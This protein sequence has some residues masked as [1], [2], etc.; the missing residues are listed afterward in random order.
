MCVWDRALRSQ[1]QITYYVLNYQNVAE[2]DAHHFSCIGS[3]ACGPW[4][5]HYPELIRC[6]R[7]ECRK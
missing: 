6:P 2:L 1:E 7:L 3:V 5:R 4:L